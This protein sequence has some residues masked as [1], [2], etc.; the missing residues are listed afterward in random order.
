MCY[1][2]FGMGCLGG[3]SIA[4]KIEAIVGIAALA[5]LGVT[6]IA[7]GTDSGLLQT[8]VA[9]IIGITGAVIGFTFGKSTIETGAG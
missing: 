5:A 7:T 1:S 3:E 9:G 4:T 8:L 6:A 2:S